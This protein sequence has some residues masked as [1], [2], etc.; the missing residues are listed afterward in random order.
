[1]NNQNNYFKNSSG[2]IT[3]EIEISFKCDINSEAVDANAFVI[4]NQGDS[5]VNNDTASLSHTA[6]LNQNQTGV[7]LW[8]GE[9]STDW[10]DCLNWNKGVI[11]NSAVDV[12]ISD[13][14]INQPVIDFTSPLRPFGAVAQSRSITINSGGLLTM[15][16]NSELHIYGDWTNFGDFVPGNGRVAFISFESDQTIF[17]IAE[18]PSFYNLTINTIDYKVLVANDQGL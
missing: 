2:P 18:E 10:F 3:F 11:P 14:A 9:T 5:N 13:A 17:D 1:G 15:N 4:S 16:D 7:G 6:I 8:L 12:T